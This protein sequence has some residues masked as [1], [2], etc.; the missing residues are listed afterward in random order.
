MAAKNN[1]KLQKLE[2]PIPVRNVNGI[3]ICDL[4]KTNIILEMLWL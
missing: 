1:F 2:R 3:N 4:E